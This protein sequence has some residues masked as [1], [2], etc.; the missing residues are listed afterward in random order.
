MVGLG[1]FIIGMFVNVKS[2]LL[3]QRA[4]AKGIRDKLLISDN[5]KYDP[6][7]T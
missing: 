4:K 6:T 5:K 3:L 7:P 2:D 1:G